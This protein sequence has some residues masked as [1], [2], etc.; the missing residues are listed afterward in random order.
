M[1]SK[2]TRPMTTG[3]PVVVRLKK[4][5]SSGRR[6]GRAPLRPMRRSG[7]MATMAVRRMKRGGMC[8][9]R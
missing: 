3:W 8:V 5:R 2:V 4:R 1:D 9:V 6:H 7:V